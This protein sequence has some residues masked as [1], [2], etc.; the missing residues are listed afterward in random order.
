MKRVF[1]II[2]L[3]GIFVYF[4]GCAGKSVKTP[5]PDGYQGIYVV[6]VWEGDNS[7]LPKDLTGL[8]LKRKGISYDITLSNIDEKSKTAE[9]IE[10][11]DFTYADGE[12]LIKFGG[13]MKVKP[14]KDGLQ[15]TLDFYGDGKA[16]K[17]FLKKI[18]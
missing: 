2:L 5:V 13:L 9:E 11:L 14:V 1:L 16:E 12:F 6:K 3:S 18:K 15:G 17:L 10:D 7:V 4:S 8:V